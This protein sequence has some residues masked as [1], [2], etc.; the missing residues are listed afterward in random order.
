MVTLLFIGTLTMVTHWL[1]LI[2]FFIPFE[3]ECLETMMD[4]P[5]LHD[6][7]ISSFLCLKL[8]LCLF[9]GI[10]GNRTSAW[11][12]LSK[13]FDESWHSSSHKIQV[14]VKFFKKNL[15]KTTAHNSQRWYLYMYNNYIYILHNLL[16]FTCW[17]FVLNCQVLPSSYHT[18]CCGHSPWWHWLL[19]SVN[20]GFHAGFA[21][22]F[23]YQKLHFPMKTTFLYQVVISSWWW[24]QVGCITFQLI[25]GFNQEFWWCQNGFKSHLLEHLWYHNYR[26][27]ISE[28]S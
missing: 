20:D 6:P 17:T 15:L 11:K 10:H 4:W 26:D 5:K 18:W 21:I 24:F 14:G 23:V 27:P 2:I 22:K 8:G 19:R 12:P 28:Y 3:L 7:I 9:W 13:M 25:T 16:P 1:D